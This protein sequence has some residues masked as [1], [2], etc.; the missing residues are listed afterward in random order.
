MM[1]ESTG[2]ARETTLRDFFAVVFRRS[3]IILVVMAAALATVLVMNSAT[4]PVYVSSA[5][6][7]V[8][9]GEPES[10]YNS[11]TILLSWDEELNSE[12]EII[13]SS[14]LGDR[15]QKVLTDAK[16]VDSQGQP[17]VY[18]PE[19]VKTATSGRASVILISYSSTDPIV[20]RESLRALVRAYSEWRTQA[21]SVPAVDTFFQ[22]EL[23]SLRDQ[24]SQWEQRRADFMSDEGIVSLPSERESLLREKEAATLEVTSVRT[25]LA[26]YAAR[27]EAVRALQQEKKVDSNV[28]IFGLG[29]ADFNDDDLLATLRRELLVRQSDYFQKRAKLADDH[30][31]VL[32][33]KQLV[34][35][36]QGEIDRMTDNYIR[37]LDAR[38]TIARA[39]IGSLDTTLRG[40]E[41]ELSG[42]PDKEARLTQYDRILDAL[43]TDYQM[44]VERQTTAR[45][46]T[47]GRAEWRVVVLQPATVALYQRTRDIIRMALVPLFALL[48]GLALAFVIDGMDHSIKDPTEV[49]T[50]LGLPVL[51]SISKIR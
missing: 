26:D 9:R 32:A 22:E 16:S 14:T 1:N 41:D 38:I 2:P 37:F 34:D 13:R 42:M 35:Q 25:R 28:E 15:V 27:L 21:R 23:E 7:L 3:G 45:A 10:V 50:H 51:G 47:T 24:L 46:E 5:R 48:I 8:S 11:R 6:I 49:E 44:M 12:M 29:D 17:I 4:R 36:L 31:D 40:I 30:P 39:R 43:K 20:A 33:A 19:N 18:K